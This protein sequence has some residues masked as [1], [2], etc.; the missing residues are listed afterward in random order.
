MR[1]PGTRSDARPVGTLE[2]DNGHSAV[3]ESF[4]DAATLVCNN[5]GVGKRR[6]IVQSSLR[7]QC[8]STEPGQFPI[9]GRFSNLRLATL[10]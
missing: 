1:L 3:Q 7:E 6:A 2:L 10:I 4:R 8:F 9:I 5:P